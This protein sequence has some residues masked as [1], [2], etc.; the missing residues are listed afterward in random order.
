MNEFYF[1]SDNWIY[2][3]DLRMGRCQKYECDSNLKKLKYNL[4]G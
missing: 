2:L 4:N 3:Y 1:S